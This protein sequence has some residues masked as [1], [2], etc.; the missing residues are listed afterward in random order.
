[1]NQMFMCRLSSTRKALYEVSKEKTQLEMKINYLHEENINLQHDFEK[2]ATELSV[3]QSFEQKYNALQ[4]ELN[5]L[6]AE[7]KKSVVIDLENELTYCKNTVQQLRKHLEVERLKRIEIEN[8]V[9]SLRENSLLSKQL[10]QL[11]TTS[12]ISAPEECGDTLKRSLHHHEA[13]N[14]NA[15]AVETIH[16]ANNEITALHDIKSEMET[17]FSNYHLRIGDLE[18]SA[19]REIYRDTEEE[20]QS[21]SGEEMTHQFQHYEDSVDSNESTDL[22]IA[23]RGPML[24]S[25]KERLKSFSEISNS[26]DEH[27]IIKQEQQMT[28]NRGIKRKCT[29]SLDDEI[30]VTETPIYSIV[31]VASDDVEIHTSSIDAPNGREKPHCEQE[32]FSIK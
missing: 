12:S 32:K 14:A 30:N 9:E 8:M 7:Q 20:R 24:V 29:T 4:S 22:E 25:E 16:N 1:M 10:E 19:A 31:S 23:T 2:K 5:A 13:D 6:V 27:Q 18:S 11:L 3:A 28:E 21:S 26:N 17:E 15:T